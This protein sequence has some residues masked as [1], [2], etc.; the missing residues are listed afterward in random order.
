MSTKHIIMVIGITIQFC[1][2]VA[3]SQNK[4][5]WYSFNN[6]FAA[7]TSGDI[8]VRSA[9]G[10]SFVG[11]T[12]ANDIQILSGF[13]ADPRL[14]GDIT[15]AVDEEQGLPTS[16]SLGQNYPNPFNPSTTIRY[17]LPQSGF[18]EIQIFDLLGQQVA[19]PVSEEKEAGRY[20]ITWDGINKNGAQATS[21]VYFYRLITKNFTQTKKFM[22]LK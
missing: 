5:S 6:G 18:V 12:Q 3:F 16:Y 4:V 22:L 2:V 19:A 1:S 20:S 14:R 10:Q 21:G 7:S 9:A 8:M 17:E 15:V 11:T 13:L